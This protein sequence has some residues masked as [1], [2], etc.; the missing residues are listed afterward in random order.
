MERYDRW[1][2]NRG[3]SLIDTISVTPGA[4]CEQSKHVRPQL[5]HASFVPLLLRIGSFQP[6]RMKWQV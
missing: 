3:Q 2:N 1:R 4:R 5:N 6:G